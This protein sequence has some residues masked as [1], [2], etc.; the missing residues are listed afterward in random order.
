MSLLLPL[1]HNGVNTAVGGLVG[2]RCEIRQLYLEG[3]SA[4]DAGIQNGGGHYSCA[5]SY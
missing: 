4:V 2:L 5:E 3:R 1:D